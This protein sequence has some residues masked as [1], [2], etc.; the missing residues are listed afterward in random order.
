[1]AIVF[2]LLYS[3]FLF[4]LLKKP[5]NFSSAVVNYLL[6]PMF[7]ITYIHIFRCLIFVYFLSCFVKYFRIEAL[8]ICFFLNLL[9]CE[10]TYKTRTD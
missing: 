4:V 1:M 2:C 9:D 7:V 5:S 10:S 6:N 8:I 3:I